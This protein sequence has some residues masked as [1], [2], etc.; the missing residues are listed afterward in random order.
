MKAKQ[1]KKEAAAAVTEVFSTVPLGK[2][3][4]ET[5]REHGGMGNI[6]VLT[7]SIRRHGLA[8]PPTVVETDAGFY[9]IVAGRRRIAAVLS[10]G[11]QEVAVK[12]LSGADEERLEA[13]ALSENVNRLEMH[14]LDEAETFRRQLEGGKSV[15]DV[16]AC[17]DR[18]PSAITHRIR[19]CGLTDE[20]KK[21]FREG[22]VTLNA[23]S[24]LSSLLP[25]D[26]VK[27]A[28]K[29]KGKK[30][31]GWD[32]VEFIRRAHN[33]GLEHIADSECEICKNRTHNSDPGL[34]EEFGT[35]TDVCFDTACYERKWKALIASLIAGAGGKPT[36]NILIFH[37]AM[38]VFYP[39][40]S[41]TIKLG[42]TEY[43]I[44]PWNNYA[45]SETDKKTKANTAWSVGLDENRKVE[46]KRVSYKPH[47]PQNYSG[48]DDTPEEQVKSYGVDQAFGGLPEEEQKELAV[49]TA[50]KYK[51]ASEFRHEVIERLLRRIVD[52][53]LA[54]GI[55]ENTAELYLEDKFSGCD[56]PD[57]I[58]K[59]FTDGRDKEIF[60]AVFGGTY[61]KFSDFS[62]PPE[63]QKMFLFLTAA[64]LKAHDLP[65]IFS[66]DADG[67]E[68]DEEVEE[69][70]FWKFTRIGRDE[71]YAMVKETIAEVI[72]EAAESTEAAYVS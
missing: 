31:S 13:I 71:Y 2:I 42:G 69:S 26:Q 60:D 3:L 5:N 30:P 39:K 51:W 14:P 47:V 53:R 23:A 61:T 16:A 10:L 18:T 7:E 34:F 19:L 67:G 48:R 20:V 9:R 29:Y 38:P 25:A 15:K 50:S 43:S 59:Q 35:L 65:D 37:Y 1:K 33:C 52:K 21:M 24:L 56:Y 45:V 49:K 8:N 66:D 64:R 4:A 12:I 40:K 62:G 72:T 68:W 58:Y 6:D 41:E 36:E 55:R 57:T 63:L 28:E 27:F 46:V 70:L 32:V 54:E 22:A 17:Y 11:W 44:L